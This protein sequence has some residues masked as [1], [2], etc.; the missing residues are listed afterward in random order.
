V[1]ETVVASMTSCSVL[2][3]EPFVSGCHVLDA[4]VNNTQ[5][6]VY[7]RASHTKLGANQRDEPANIGV[8]CTSSELYGNWPVWLWHVCHLGCRAYKRCSRLVSHPTRE[9]M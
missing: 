8:L 2:R 3:P 7:G 6:R 5:Y 1:S 9:T 4:Q